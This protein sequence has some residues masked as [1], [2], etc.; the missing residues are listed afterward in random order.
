MLAESQQL[1]AVAMMEFSFDR[2]PSPVAA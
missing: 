1:S 2:G